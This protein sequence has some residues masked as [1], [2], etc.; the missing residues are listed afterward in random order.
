[1][2]G[3]TGYAFYLSVKSVAFTGPELE[4]FNMRRDQSLGLCFRSLG[5]GPADFTRKSNTLRKFAAASLLIMALAHR[6][7]TQ[8]SPETV[9]RPPKGSHFAIVLFQDLQCPMCARTAPLIE[10]ASREYRIPVVLHDFP[11][12]M[13]TW[14]RQAAVIARYFD[15]HSK[16]L[17][18]EFRDCIFQHQPDINPENLNAYAKEFASEHDVDFPVVPDPE[19]R[20]AALVD[21]DF[22]LGKAIK[23]SHIPMV[24]L[25]SSEH[26]ETPYSEVNDS[27]QL[28]A[29][30]A[31]MIPERA[32][33]SSTP[34]Q[35]ASQAVCPNLTGG[36]VVITKEH[37]KKGTAVE[38][39]TE[40]DVLD[41]SATMNALAG[42]MTS[43]TP[44]VANDLG[45]RSD[46][47]SK[48]DSDSSAGTVRNSPSQGSQYVDGI[49]PGQCTRDEYTAGNLWIIN[50]CNKSVTVMWT[51]D[52][53][54]GWGTTDIGA[55]GRQM[56][57]AAGVGYTR[58]DGRVWL[59]TCPQ[60]AV[61]VMP[62]GSEIS[63]TNYKGTFKCHK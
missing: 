9:F 51:T 35:S 21:A 14:S 45:R 31:V 41:L 7:W 30:I 42:N 47:S 26:P 24:Y 22:D 54:N 52:S 48:V 6:G 32:V 39:E 43:R 10:K 46:T 58:K 60:G 12:P 57:S 11:L 50:R 20:I 23:I 55:D 15:T 4:M 34:L 59:F 25:V 27:S 62:N 3:L 13:H 16:A 44:S 8:D 18:I 49:P 63:S 28:S 53:G 40:S 61:P 38:A 17:G 37:Q 56:V 33:V 29:L 19:G 5:C 36:N 1:V 2:V